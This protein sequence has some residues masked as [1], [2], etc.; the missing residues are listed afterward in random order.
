MIF[1]GYNKK[2]LTRDEKKW[3]EYESFE[4]ESRLDPSLGGGGGGGAWDNRGGGGNTKTILEVSKN[5]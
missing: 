4:Y 2:I 3:L 1:S 5:L